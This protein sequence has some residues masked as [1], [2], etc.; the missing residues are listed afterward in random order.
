M[1]ISGTRRLLL[2][3]VLVPLLGACASSLRT[4]E[5][6]LA[7]AEEIWWINSHRAPCTGVGPMHCLLVHDR[8]E[9]FGPWRFHYD[10]IEGFDFRAGSLYRLRLEQIELPPE[11]VPADASSI[12]YRLLEVLEQRPDPRAPIN[13]IFAVVW[14][15]AAADPSTPPQ[16][17]MEFSIAQAR[18]AGHDGCREFEGK[19]LV[20]NERQLQLAPP[21]FRGQPCAAGDDISVLG[22]GLEAVSAWQRSGMRLQLL[23]ADSKVLVELRK[24]D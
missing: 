9:P 16:A 12:R 21:V 22:N 24:I 6:A 3:G 1:K 8:P 7:A 15:L 4:N 20:L 17:R 2:I 18:Y 5:P 13:D 19:I 10:E 11:Q 14:P 23:D